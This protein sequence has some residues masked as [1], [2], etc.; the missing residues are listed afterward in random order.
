MIDIESV[1]RDLAVGR[2]AVQRLEDDY[3]AAVIDAHVSAI[4]KGENERERKLEAERAV[5]NSLR[6]QERLS[7]LRE[8]QAGVAI[9]EA[10]LLIYKLRLRE[11]ELASPV[12]ASDWRLP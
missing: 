9:L 5:R 6:C 7:A 12:A 8:A 3:D 11:R 1:V 4:G 2:S 10:E